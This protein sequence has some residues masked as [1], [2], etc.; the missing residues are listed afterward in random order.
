MAAPPSAAGHDE[1]DLRIRDHE[2]VVR[3]RYE[4]VS[5]LN[6]VLVALWFIA[7]SIL[8]FS[9][10]TTTVGV[11]LFLAGSIELLIRP[12]IRLTRCIHLKRLGSPSQVGGTS[13]F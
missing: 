7:G 12:V 4:I 5:I 11:W 6:D 1:W 13:G 2:L 3:G 8:F 10:S 9:P